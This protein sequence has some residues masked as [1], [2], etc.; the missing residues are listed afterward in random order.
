MA[1]PLWPPTGASSLS[2]HCS[3]PQRAAAALSGVIF[4]I[5][6]TISSIIIISSSS[7]V[8]PVLHLRL[9]VAVS[10]RGEAQ[11]QT[12]TA[13]L[14]AQPFPIDCLSFFLQSLVR[15]SSSSLSSS[16]PASSS[17]SASLPPL[18]P[19]SKRASEHAF[20][21]LS[22]PFPFSLVSLSVFGI[23]ERASERSIMAWHGMAYTDGRVRCS[24]GGGAWVEILL[25]SF[26]VDLV[27]LFL[28]TYFLLGRGGR[29][30]GREKGTE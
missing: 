14:L 20:S 4:G 8:Q 5:I 21:G 17:S 16:L 23:M 19:F 29:K 30:E 10:L 13:T 7:I 11:R 18:R 9:L 15:A 6:F 2:L 1:A 27:V 24:W 12:K 22:F 26:T 25:F 3:A 28:C